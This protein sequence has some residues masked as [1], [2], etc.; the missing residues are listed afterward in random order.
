MNTIRFLMTD[1]SIL[2]RIGCSVMGRKFDG[3]VGSP[4]LYI[5]IVNPRFQHV[6]IEPKFQHS[7]IN[8]CNI[9]RRMGHRFRTITDIWSRGHGDAL[10]LLLLIALVTSAYVGGVVRHGCIGVGSDGIQSGIT[11]FLNRKTRLR[12]LLKYSKH[13]DV[14]KA[15][16]IF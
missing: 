2:Y 1:A 11:H 4:F 12:I 8:L 7:V 10:D 3:S 9:V 5:K 13:D 15:G 16:N 14:L 6:G